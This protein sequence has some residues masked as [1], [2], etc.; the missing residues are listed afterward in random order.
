METADLETPG[1]RVPQKQQVQTKKGFFQAFLTLGFRG[2]EANITVFVFH[3]PFS[4]FA[5]SGSCFDE[6]TAATSQRARSPIAR[7]LG[8]SA[9]ALP[10]WIKVLAA[11]SVAH[12][13]RRGAMAV[14]S[15]TSTLCWANAKTTRSDRTLRT[16]LLASLVTRSSW[17]YY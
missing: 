3:V 2:K 4:T 16:G 1:T 12:G 9:I 17:P 15:M 7:C 8:R 10:Q 6:P 11:L 13:S 14:G 5:P